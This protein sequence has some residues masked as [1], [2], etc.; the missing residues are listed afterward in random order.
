MNA[1]DLFLK[2]SPLRLFFLTALP[3]AIS[4]LASALYGIFDGVFVGNIVGDTA[5]AAINLAFPFVILNYALSDLIAVGS[6]VPISIALGKKEDERANHIFSASVILIIITGLAMGLFLYT[7][8]P[9]FMKLLGAKGEL[10]ELAVSYVRVYALF[11]PLTTMTFAVDNFLRISGKIKFSMF[12]NVGMSL[13]TIVL[14]FVFLFYLQLGIAGAALASCLS[15]AVMVI[16]AITP[17]L[18]RRLQLKFMRPTFSRALLKQIIACGSP[19][20]LSNIAGRI[21]SIVMN[22]ALLSTGGQDAVSIWGIL[23]YVG[24]TIQP[25]VYGMCDA[26]SPAIGYNYGAGL[27]SRVK[28]LAR[29]IYTASAIVSLFAALLMLFVPE[30]L[31]SLFTKNTAPE[32]VSEATAALRIYAFSRFTVWFS[33]ATQIY[34]TAVDRPLF[35]TVISLASSLV[36][37]VALVFLLSSLGLT[38]LWLNPTLTAALTALLALIL[39]LR[40]QKKMPKEDKPIVSPA[41][42]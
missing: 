7:A 26:L 14:E 36:I 28:T 23:M 8:S 41:A 27:F 37:P 4:M 24:E 34:M 19:A 30:M 6:A 10:A 12:L 33:F 32:F 42:E 31:V 38:G 17:F 9:L 25:I 22:A 11:S 2:T 35:A 1:K 20:F 16:I 39:F 13:G 29:Y 3:G 18:L 21:T 15:M 5:F 40:F